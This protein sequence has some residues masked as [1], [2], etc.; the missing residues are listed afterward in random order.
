MGED[1]GGAHISASRTSTLFEGTFLPRKSAKPKANNVRIVLIQ[2]WLVHVRDRPHLFA[3]DSGGV[4]H[5]RGRSKALALVKVAAHQRED[6]LRTGEVPN[7][8]EDEDALPRIE[9]KALRD[10]P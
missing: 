3:H 8:Q 5:G 10:M 4:V 1:G 6:R 2:I 9:L 7:R